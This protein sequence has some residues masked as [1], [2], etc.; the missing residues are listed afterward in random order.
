MAFTEFYVQTTGSN[1]NAGSTADNAAPFTYAA[2]TFVQSTRVFT[3]ASGN[4]QSDGV[5]VGMFASI[6]TTAGATVAT[7]VGRVSAVDATTI[8]VDGLVLAG[9]SDSRAGLPLGHSWMQ[10][11]T[12]RE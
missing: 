7:F 1:L 11:A 2:G 3:V 12:R 10:V 5:T 4:P 8:T 6:Y 9:Q